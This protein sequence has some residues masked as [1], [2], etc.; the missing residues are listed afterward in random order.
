MAE[1]FFLEKP[2]DLFAQ[3]KLLPC[4]EDT[5]DVKLN[6][7]TRLVLVLTLIFILVKWKHWQTFLVSSLI[8]IIFV[9]LIK[10]STYNEYFNEDM[11]DFKYYDISS[12]RKSM[13]NQPRPGRKMQYNSA[14]KH[15]KVTVKTNNEVQDIFEVNEPVTMAEDLMKEIAFEPEYTHIVMEEQPYKIS[16]KAK[17]HPEPKTAYELEMESY[18]GAPENITVNRK[19]LMGSMYF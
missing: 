13:H 19:A 14:Q 1:R 2:S 15:N 10:D 3:F 9:Y 5:I 6:S 16:A 11:D 12:S 7:I 17:V 4:K 18:R 8:L